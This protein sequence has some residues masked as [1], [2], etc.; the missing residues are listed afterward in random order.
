M[1]KKRGECD[2]DSWFLSTQKPWPWMPMLAAL[3][4]VTAIVL[5][6]PGLARASP[7]ERFLSPYTVLPLEAGTTLMLGTNRTIFFLFTSKGFYLWFDRIMQTFVTQQWKQSKEKS[8]CL[9]NKKLSEK[10]V[11]S[12]LHLFSTLRRWVIDIF[13]SSY[14]NAALV[15]FH[16]YLVQ[17]VPSTLSASVFSLWL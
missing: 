13:P 17:R 9:H 11:K 6:V 16:G 3:V 15:I 7:W 10:K 5:Y 14:W 2:F 4:A 1:K 12:P 8:S